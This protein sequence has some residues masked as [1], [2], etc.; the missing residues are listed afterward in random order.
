MRYAAIIAQKSP[1]FVIFRP[2]DT[3]NYDVGLQGTH[4]KRFYCDSA[5]PVSCSIR[6]D[7]SHPENMHSHII[8]HGRLPGIANEGQMLLLS[9]IG[10][11]CVKSLISNHVKQLINNHHSPSLSLHQK[12]GVCKSDRETQGLVEIVIGCY[13]FVISTGCCML[14]SPHISFIPDVTISYASKKFRDDMINKVMQL[15]RDFKRTE[16]EEKVK[17]PDSAELHARMRK[18]VEK[19]VVGR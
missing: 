10:K 2:P 12:V 6:W 4:G 9:T 17:S 13:G 15:S 1:I 16:R 5:P 3:E 7:S 18:F 19:V 8:L 11:T 14:M